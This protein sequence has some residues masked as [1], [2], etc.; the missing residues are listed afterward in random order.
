MS[1]AA[2]LRTVVH[3]LE[4]RNP[5]VLA[6]GTAGFGEELAGV[7]RLD[8]V[9]GIVTKAVSLEPRAGNPSRRVAEFDGGMLNAVGLANPGL[10]A[11]RAGQ[12]PWLATHLAGT[13]KIVN[14]VGFAVEEYAA[15]VAGLEEALSAAS[16]RHAID[17]F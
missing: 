2:A 12:V 13:R 9:G 6:A 17:G 1:G 15:V 14:V 10:A 7:M 3:G 11:V 16:T 5:I 4:F 8:A